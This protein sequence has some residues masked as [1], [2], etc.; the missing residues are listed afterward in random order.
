MPPNNRTLHGDVEQKMA[1]LKSGINTKHADLN[2][3]IQAG[4]YTGAR[5][6]AG[7]LIESIKTY[8]RTR[9]EIRKAIE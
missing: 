1:D 5:V 3:A 4:D 7:E 8:A 6:K 9:A 2:T